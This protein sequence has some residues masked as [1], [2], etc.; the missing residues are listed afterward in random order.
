MINQFKN[1][2]GVLEHFMGAWNRVG[3]GFL[4]LSARLHGL[5]ESVP[6]NRFLDFLKV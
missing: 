2:A 6:W 3:I 4:Y 5:E 1:S